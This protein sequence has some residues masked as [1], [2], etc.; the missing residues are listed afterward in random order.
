MILQHAEMC[1]RTATATVLS[2]EVGERKRFFGKI[3]RTAGCQQ[4]SAPGGPPWHPVRARFPRK[5]ASRSGWTLQ[6]F[7]RGAHYSPA[8][9][10]GARPV[11]GWEL[12]QQRGVLRCGLGRLLT[13][14][15]P[16][17]QIP[18][19]LDDPVDTTPAQPLRLVLVRLAQHRRTVDTGRPIATAMVRCP[20]PFRLR[21]QAFPMTSVV[22][23]LRMVNSAGS[24]I[25]VTPKS[26]QRARRGVMETRSSPT[27]RT[28][29]VPA[30]AVRVQAPRHDGQGIAPACRV[31]TQSDT[32]GASPPA[33]RSVRW[34]L[35]DRTG[36]PAAVDSRCPSM[37]PGR[38][39]MLV[40]TKTASVTVLT[41]RPPGLAR[42][43]SVGGRGNDLPD[44]AA[45]L[46]CAPKDKASGEHTKMLGRHRLS[47][48]RW[49]AV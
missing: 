45:P 44:D 47:C 25:W 4:L 9:A 36:L 20:A 8:G 15:R 39:V 16:D 41:L 28:V 12:R 22:S 43:R 13:A 2:R 38:A 35:A 29:R 46:L 26:P 49:P 34:T 17:E 32:S 14:P 19:D 1:C 18:I 24:R 11:V 48:R 31:L 5:G 37:G 33:V 6:W 27:P 42:I 10:G 21:N 7:P 3:L 40:R 23:A 30:V